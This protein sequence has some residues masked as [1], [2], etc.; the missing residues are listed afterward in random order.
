MEVTS[1][2]MLESSLYPLQGSRRKPTCLASI[3]NGDKG[4]VELAKG[5]KI[6]FPSVSV[7]P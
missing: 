6:I 4:L 3:R 2:M 7:L 5:N 1:W